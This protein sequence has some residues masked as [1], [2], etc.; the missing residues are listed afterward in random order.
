MIQETLKQ[1]RQN[2]QHAAKALGLSHQGLI[3][4]MKRYRIK[5]T[6]E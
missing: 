6:V 3:K 1:C 4:K 2:Q 5:A